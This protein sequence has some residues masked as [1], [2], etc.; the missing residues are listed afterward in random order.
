MI[1]S[2][3]TSTRRWAG[4][5]QIEEDVEPLYL[6]YDDYKKRLPLPPRIQ[7]ASGCNMT[8]KQRMLNAYRGLPNDR[9]AVAP[10]FWYY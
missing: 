4:S 3:T 1:T 5:P 8:G 10:E 7:V 2:T 6:L 9:P